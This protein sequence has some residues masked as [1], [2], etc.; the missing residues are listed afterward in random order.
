MVVVNFKIT[1]YTFFKNTLLQY[2]KHEEKKRE[3]FILL[4]L[5]LFSLV[6]SEYCWI[7]KC[8]CQLGFW[9]R[10]WETC[11]GNILFIAALQSIKSRCDVTYGFKAHL[12]IFSSFPIIFFSIKQYQLPERYC[13]VQYLMNLQTDIQVCKS[14]FASG[15]C[16]GSMPCLLS[17]SLG[18]D[19]YNMVTS[20]LHPHR[21]APAGRNIFSSPCGGL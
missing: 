18:S 12:L 13:C 4:Y 5:F 15:S 7:W 16:P 11:Q 14:S 1:F 2:L 20:V 21:I 10:A 19:I 17:W 9:F 8:S 3:E 6:P